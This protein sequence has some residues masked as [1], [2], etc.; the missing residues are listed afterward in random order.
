MTGGVQAVA[1]N[2]EA[3]TLVPTASILEYSSRTSGRI[4]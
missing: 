4:A 1:V 3:S 2:T